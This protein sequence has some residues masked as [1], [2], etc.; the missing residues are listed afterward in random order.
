M[1]YAISGAILAVS[2]LW[3]FYPGWAASMAPQGWH[4]PERVARRTMGESTL[5]DAGVRLM[6]AGNP[7]GW[8]AIVDAAAMRQANR[9]AIAACE[10][11]AEKAKEPVRCTIRVGRP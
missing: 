5:W 3:L 6:Q 8:Q 10:R 9:D 7:E 4:W 11:A 2:L 1:L